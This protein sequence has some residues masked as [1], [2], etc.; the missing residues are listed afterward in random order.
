MSFFKRLRAI[1]NAEVRGL[2]RCSGHIDESNKTIKKWN[3]SDEVYTNAGFKIYWELLEDVRNYQ[4]L[5][6]TKGKDFNEYV[7]SFFPE[8]K[9]LSNLNGLIIVCNYG[10]EAPSISFAKTGAFRK[11]L[12]IDLADGLLRRQEQIT[13]KLGLN[14]IIK[15]HCANFNVESIAGKNTYDFIY[16]L[17]TI[18]HIRRLEGLFAEI[19]NVLQEDGIFTMR[20]YVGPSYLQF[21]EKQLKIANR[22]LECLPDYLKMQKDGTTKRTA[23]KPTIE[24]IIADDPSEAV[25]SQD[26]IGIVYNS[27]DVL[28]AT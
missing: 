19:N 28:P 24:E 6:M 10:E 3:K 18:H 11:L 17:G 25:R 1:F 13:D 14:H 16:S 23:W 20:E 21:T 22:I 15:Y 2:A 9:K 8:D 27:L 12:I 4:E 26:I 7:K 5:M